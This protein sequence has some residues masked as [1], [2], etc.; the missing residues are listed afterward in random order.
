[1]FQ[2]PARTPLILM[3]RAVDRVAR[4]PLRQAVGPE[5]FE[6]QMDWLHRNGMRGVSVGE[7][8]HAYRAG[9]AR[10]LVGLTFDRGYATFAT[11]AVPILLRRGFTAT[12]FVSAAEIGGRADRDPGPD[13]PL[14]TE[15][16]IRCV[17]GKGMEIGS[18]GLHHVPLPSLD[19]EE[20]AEELTRARAVLEDV[21]GRA[22]TG[23][24]YPYGHVSPREM[25]AVRKAGYEYA[26]A[27]RRGPLDG[28]HALP[29]TRVDDRDGRIRL[30]IKV[31]RHQLAI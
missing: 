26:C 9:L 12:V 28:D 29:R 17:A 20:L 5:L 13:R 19:D 4:D 16:Q 22:V 30:R 2:R 1:M 15:R 3:Y 18:H 6:R 14:M 31:L 10:G 24:A 27:V 11:R 21:T 23:F 7:L 8:R 25:T